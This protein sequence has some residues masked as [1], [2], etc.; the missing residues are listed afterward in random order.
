M[1]RRER[2]KRS[3]LAPR[4]F[5]TP[6][7]WV[8]TQP[9]PDPGAG[10]SSSR[11][12][13]P[14][15][16]SRILAWSAA[17][18]FLLAAVALV[19]AASR[20]F[21]GESDPD[22]GEVTSATAAQQRAERE[23]PA[24]ERNAKAEPEPQAEPESKVAPDTRAEGESPSPVP[25]ESAVAAARAQAEPAATPA[26]ANAPAHAKTAVPAPSP[27]NAGRGNRAARAAAAKKSYRE[28]IRL[29][30]KGSFALAEKKFREALA[31]SPGYALAHKGL[32]ILY[33][34]QGK[35][36]LAVQQYRFY[37]RSRPKDAE[38]VKQ[39]IQRLSR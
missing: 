1:Q 34:K 35:N 4:K 24:V 32:G 22:P 20:R 31:Q 21:G 39:R 2:R 29:Y 25:A 19:V 15:R 7:R 11:L 10:P 5:L 28:G 37:L 8:P 14:R 3:T 18:V 9:T 27:A 13:A 12:V 6:V 33:Q 30:V 36:K 38:N 16:N 23:S 26:K 17:T